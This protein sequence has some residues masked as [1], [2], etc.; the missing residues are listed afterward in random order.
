MELKLSD[1]ECKEILSVGSRSQKETV[2]DIFL[3]DNQI[4]HLP[5][6][7]FEFSNI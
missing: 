2:K 1:D 3:A 6:D 5:F 4:E 7:P